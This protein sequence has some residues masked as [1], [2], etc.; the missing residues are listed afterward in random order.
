[1]ATIRSGDEALEVARDVSFSVEA[2]FA[3]DFDA[4]EEILPVVAVFVG[5][6]EEAIGVDEVDNEAV[7][8][9]V[10]VLFAYDVSYSIGAVFGVFA[11][12]EESAMV[13]AEA[14]AFVL[15]EWTFSD[16]FQ[17]VRAE[18]NEFEGTP[19]GPAFAGEDDF[20]DSSPSLARRVFF[21]A[22]ADV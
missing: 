19:S 20:T 18:A 11:F 14:E 6:A 2:G 9:V 22:V 8:D 16:G 15:L 21:H 13:F 1:L 7:A 5:G 3:G 4:F 17:V 12:V 10:V